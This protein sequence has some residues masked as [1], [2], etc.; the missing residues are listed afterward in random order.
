MTRSPESHK[1]RL[2]IGYVVGTAKLQG[3]GVLQEP[4][5]V[6]LQAGSV[7]TS[8]FSRV[9]VCVFSQCVCVCVCVCVRVPAGVCARV[10]VCMSV[11]WSVGLHAHIRMHGYMRVCTHVLVR[12]FV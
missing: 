7:C 4:G 6:S 2:Q 5:P 8:V 10:S 12:T 3:D 11:C 1:P 9:R